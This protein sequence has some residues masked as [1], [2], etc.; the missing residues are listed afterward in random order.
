MNNFPTINI[1]KH[2]NKL[3]SELIN[4]INNKTKPT[5]ALGVLENIALKIALH[6]NNL[7][8]KLTNPHIV[9]FAGDH[10]IAQEG[11]SAFPQEVT[12]QM[13]ENFLAGGA[14]INVF[15]KN[16]NI[17]LIIVDAGVNHNFQN[18]QLINAKVGNGTKSF[19]TQSAMTEDECLQAFRQGQNIVRDIYKRGCNVIGFG[20]MGIGNTSAASLITHLLTSIPLEDCVGKGTGLSDDKLRQ[21]HKILNQALFNFRNKNPINQSLANVFEVARYFGGFEIVMMAGALAGAGEL[22]MTLIVDG[23][24]CTAAYLIAYSINN[25]IADY[26][27][28]SHCSAEQG[29]IKQLNW[30]KVNPLLNLGLRLGE[31]T[32]VALAYPLVQQAVAMLNEMASFDSA[33]VSTSN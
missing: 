12:W 7:T 31:G 4:K 32:G 10:G 16:A 6:Q 19:L 5:G 23:F 29:H 17:N 9:I 20:E 3:Q 30:L 11:V 14:A 21:K 33:Q 25:N 1:E 13:V 28:F 18:R 15:A 22:K 26:A 2:D 27:I 8:P 24:I